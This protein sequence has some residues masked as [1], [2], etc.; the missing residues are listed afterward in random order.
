MEKI[1][2]ITKALIV[3][4]ILVFALLL[5]GC[6]DVKKYKVKITFCDCRAPRTIEMESRVEP[7]NLDINNTGQALTSFHGY[8][9]ICDVSVVK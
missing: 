4:T 6:R 2:H 7:S 9:N 8:L 5:S 1:R 3:L